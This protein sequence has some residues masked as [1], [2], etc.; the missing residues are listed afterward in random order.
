MK[1]LDPPPAPVG[2]AAL[3]EACG[4]VII[5]RGSS[6]PLG[7]TQDGGITMTPFFTSREL[8]RTV[9]SSPLTE[10]TLAGKKD[11]PFAYL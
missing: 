2:G 3:G 6:F 5:L 10:I 1:V 8:N 4:I 11:P 9:I 7:T